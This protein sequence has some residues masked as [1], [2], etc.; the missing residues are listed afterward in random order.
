MRRRGGMTMTDIVKSTPYELQP[1]VDA[2]SA[3]L[4]KYL[5]YLGLPAESVLVRTDERAK[6]IRNLP[7]VVADLT[8]EQRDRAM[9]VSK[10]VAACGAGLFDAALNF[11]W[12]ETIVNLRKKVARFDLDYFFDS[13][14]AD[15][16]R[17]AKFRLE[18]DLEELEDWELIRGC[19]TTGI[20]SDIGFK[21][22]DYIR[23][24]RNWAS[25]AHPNQNQLSGLQ[26]ISWLE[27][28][29]R[30]VLAKEPE[31]PVLEVHRLIVNLRNQQLSSSDSPSIEGNIKLLPP[32]LILSLLRSIFGMFTDPNLAA[33]TKQNIRVIAP[34]V[35]HAATDEDRYEIGLKYAVFSA[36]AE[37][38]RK[39]LAYEFLQLVEGLSFLP[40]DQLTIELNEKLDNLATAHFG[41]DNF[42]TE[43]PHAKILAQYVPESGVIPDA[44]LQK[45]VKTLVLCR[46]GNGHGISWAAK[47]Y[48]DSLINRFQDQHGFAFVKLLFDSDVASRFQFEYCGGV[49]RRIA[50]DLLSRTSNVH[51]QSLLN[52]IVSKS[53]Q[54]LPDLGNDTR[55]KRA[56]EAAKTA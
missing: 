23:D 32:D 36:N 9:Y 3:G 51:L 8:S 11:L 47:G 4:I 42:Y 18:E 38:N 53:V 55:F 41:F 2:Y 30:E 35:W 33:N 29:I 20:L 40:T 52:M 19:R 44:V 25:A 13:V 46:M 26:V 48:Y 21:H 31:G 1:H 16:D 22:L 50:R 6:V 45:Y 17:R 12:N 43:S 56:V 15:S 7:D 24:M 28:C 10:F 37:I 34:A 14:I 54:R 49:F 5:T 39:N 27:T